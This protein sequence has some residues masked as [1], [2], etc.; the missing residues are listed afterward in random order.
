[1]TEATPAEA[2]PFEDLSNKEAMWEHLHDHHGWQAASTL[3]NKTHGG[4]SKVTRS[5]MIKWHGQLH[6]N[7]S[8]KAQAVQHTHV[9]LAPVVEDIAAEKARREEAIRNGDAYIGSKPLTSAERT[10]LRTLVD[11]DF[12]TLRS[13]MRQFAD[14]TMTERQR[15]VIADWADKRAEAP[16]YVQQLAAMVANSAAAIKGVMAKAQADGI[17]IETS[18]LLYRLNNADFGFDVEGEREAK[19]K[20]KQEVEQDLNR[21][22]LTLERQRLSVHRRILLASVPEGAQSLISQLPTANKLMLEAAQAREAQKAIGDKVDA[23]RE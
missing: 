5:E 19:L 7:V 3:I 6:E 23:G 8:E 4:K 14:D 1:M 17:K 2:V 16:R 15:Q 22:L 20:V 9:P 18:N 21:A 11:N 12:A 13:E 10:A